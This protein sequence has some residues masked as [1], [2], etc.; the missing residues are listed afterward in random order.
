MSSTPGTPL[1]PELPEPTRARVSFEEFLT[2]G[3][4]ET[5]A[6][7]V[8]GEIIPMSPASAEHQRLLQWVYKLLDAW[9]QARQLGEVFVAPIAMKLATRPSGREPDILFIA[10]VNAD[11]LRSTYLD[12]PADLVVEIISPESEERDRGAKFVE[13]EAGGVPAYWLLDPTRRQ[14]YFYQCDA[15]GHFQLQALDPDGRYHA[16]ALPGFWLRPAWFWQRPLPP[17]AEVLLQI[18]A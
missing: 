11:R 4:G 18:E 15:E 17:V 5:W 10:S 3:D 2:E 14:A 13:Y 7:W 12:G 6:E 8:D 16:A 9:V 1:A